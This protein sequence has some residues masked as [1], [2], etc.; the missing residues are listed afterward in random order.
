M[1]HVCPYRIVNLEMMSQYGCDAWKMYNN[2]LV[3]M[4]ES[5]QKQLNEL[6]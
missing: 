2:T 3:H 6:R 4:V 1:V 5:A